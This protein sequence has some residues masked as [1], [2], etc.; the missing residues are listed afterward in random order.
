MTSTILR[1]LVSNAIK[2]T[3]ENGKVSIKA[4]QTEEQLQVKVS[5][6]GIGMKQEVMDKLF[7]VGQKVVYNGTANEKGTGLGLLLCKELVEKN[8][9]SIHVY[10]EPEKGSSFSFTLPKTPSEKKP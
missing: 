6:T 5:D 8:G 2:F 4:I 1:N 10:S 9:G 7:V 3:P